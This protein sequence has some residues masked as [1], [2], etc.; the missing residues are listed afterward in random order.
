MRNRNL[1]ASFA[2]SHLVAALLGGA[3]SAADARTS[4]HAWDVDG[5]GVLSRAE[6]RAGMGA[7]GLYE[8]WDADRDGLLSDEEYRAHPPK[9]FT[10]AEA[11]AWSDSGSGHFAREQFEE[12]HFEAYDLDDDQTLAE[13]EFGLFLDDGAAQGWLD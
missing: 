6:F 13:R 3:V 4:F 9:H 1:P 12:R 7:V 10:A 2:A 11:E 8:L 5:N